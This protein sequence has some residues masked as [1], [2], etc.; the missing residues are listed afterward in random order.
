[1]V[2]KQEP[3]QHSHVGAQLDLEALAKHVVTSH[4][5]NFEKSSSAYTGGICYC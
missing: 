4:H 3:L 1:M 5:N 2:Q